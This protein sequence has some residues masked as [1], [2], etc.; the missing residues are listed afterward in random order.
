MKGL[1]VGEVARLIRQAVGLRGGCYAEA[2]VTVSR[3]A[4]A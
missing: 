4:E 1:E 2:Q 3:Y